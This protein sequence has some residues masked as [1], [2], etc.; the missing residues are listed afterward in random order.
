MIST[1]AAARWKVATASAGPSGQMR[2]VIG[3]ERVSTPGV[4]GQKVWA[5][6]GVGFVAGVDFGFDVCAGVRW[7]KGHGSGPGVFLLFEPQVNVAAP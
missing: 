5:I 4:G 7:Q 6:L 3:G 1:D 2:S